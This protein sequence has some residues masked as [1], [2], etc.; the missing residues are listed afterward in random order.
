MTSPASRKPLIGVTAMGLVRAFP[1]QQP[2]QESDSRIDEERAPEYQ[3]GPK[4]DGVVSGSPQREDGDHIARKA[5]AHVS[6]ENPRRR[7]VPAQKPE[8]TCAENCG[9]RRRAVPDGHWT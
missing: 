8:A 9:G 4:A 2:S 1:A 5:T 7:P 6:H 3:P